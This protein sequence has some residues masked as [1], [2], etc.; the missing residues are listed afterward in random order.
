M[1]A[2]RHHSSHPGS[3]YASASVGGSGHRAVWSRSLIAARRSL[4]TSCSSF[5]S[6]LT[7]SMHTIRRL[8]QR[9]QWVTQTEA[10]SSHLHEQTRL[11]QPRSRS[12]NCGIGEAE[13]EESVTLGRSRKRKRWDSHRGYSITSVFELRLNGLNSCVLNA[14]STSP[15]I[16]IVAKSSISWLQITCDVESQAIASNPCP[17]QRSHRS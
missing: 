5:C 12:K 14:V 2:T 10:H 8:T 1:G 13:T 4:I 15:V 6:G 16:V 9:V 17:V 11:D 7:P 3:H